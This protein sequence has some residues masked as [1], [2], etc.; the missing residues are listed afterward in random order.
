MLRAFLFLL[1]LTL[2]AS[3]VHSQCT[4]SSGTPIVLET[5]GSGANMIGPPLPAGTTNLQFVN[6]NC[7]NDGMYSIVNY[8]S[9]CYGAWHTLTDHTGDKNGYFMLINASYQ[10]SDFFVQTVSGLCDGTSYEFSAFI[11]NMF[12]IAGGIEPNVTFTIEKTDG[13]ILA[14][15]N[16]GDIAMDNP[17]VWHRHGFYF[18]TPAGVTAVVL[19]MHNNAPGG[20]GNDLGLD[21]IAFSAAGPTT[22]F[23]LDGYTGNT[24]HV[25]CTNANIHAAVGNCYIKN[26]YQWQNS[27]DGGTTWN[28]IPGQTSPDYSTNLPATGTYLYRLIIAEDGNI[29]NVNCRVISD[30][31]NVIYDPPA[32]ANVSAAIC[33]GTSYTLP[34]GKSVNQQGTYTDVLPNKQGCD[35]LI[36][37]LDL[38][39]KP[40]AYS[41]VTTQ[42]CE[43]QNYAGH[44]SSGSYIDTLTAANG[45]DSI[46]TL[47][48]TVKPRAYS[49]LNAS[50]CK[51]DNYLGYTETGKYIDTLVAFNGCDSIRTL[52]L[53]VNRASPNLGL[54]RALC[55]GDSVLLNPG[56][57]NSYIWQDGSTLPVYKVKTDGTYWVKVTDENGCTASDTITFRNVNCS[58]AN[59]PNAFTP[60]GDGTNDTWNIYALQGYPGCKVSIY[61]RYGQLVFSSINYPIPWDGKYNGKALPAGTYYYIIDLNDGKPPV[62]GYVAIVR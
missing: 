18:T 30:V 47:N 38:T 62:S 23:S 44:T 27:T 46:R 36:T 41:T 57:F 25:L 32:M 58:L 61:T 43:G 33:S 2:T 37:H 9:G 17:A 31:F 8:T 45:C 39:L 26:A 29:S 55:L 34:S 40:I 11:I 14:S 16:T 59:M 7:P 56:T 53:I 12:D 35:S 13:T 24:V 54:D 50:I 20:G 6:Y 21:D 15:Y 28:D 60:N 1:F 5:F 3:V 51:G 52:N 22:T 48:L 42:I 10:P 49:T 19:R 4:K